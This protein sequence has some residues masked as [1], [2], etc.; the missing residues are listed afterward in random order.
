MSCILECSGYYT[1]KTDIVRAQDCYLY[2]SEGKRYI[3]L[4]SGVW[5]TAL[6][7]NNERI[8]EVINK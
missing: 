7:H 2:D 3:D 4:E 5:C 8:N 6:G 1:V